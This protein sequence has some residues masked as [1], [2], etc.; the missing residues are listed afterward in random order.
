MY[1]L[2]DS[3]I[4]FLKMLG[5]VFSCMENDELA[6]LSNAALFVRAKYWKQPKCSK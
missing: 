5:S 1:L 3:E 2:F 4:T 6:K